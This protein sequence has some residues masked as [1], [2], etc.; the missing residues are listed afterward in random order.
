M[1]VRDKVAGERPEL[2][3]DPHRL[4]PGRGRSRLPCRC[5][6]GANSCSLVSRKHPMLFLM[7]VHRMRP[8]AAAVFDRPD[9]GA[10]EL[11]SMQRL[12]RRIES[13]PVDDPLPFVA[14]PP[15]RSSLKCAFCLTAVG[16]YGG[17]G[18]K[19]CPCA[20]MRLLSGASSPITIFIIGT[21][22]VVVEAALAVELGLAS[23]GHE[24]RIREIDHVAVRR[25]RAVHVTW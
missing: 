8:A 16:R 3:V 9:L 18:R 24:H 12:T 2:A 10:V 1:A 25:R 15:P 14:A 5:R 13:Q 11:G 19:F 7:D 23:V 22:Y 4:H 21:Q 20:G 6:P 17:I